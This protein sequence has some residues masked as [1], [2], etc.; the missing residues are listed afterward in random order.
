MFL[1]P[2]KVY[3]L[4]LISTSPIVAMACQ[5]PMYGDNQQ[6]N[7]MA[8]QA[9]TQCLNNEQYQQQQ[10]RQQQQQQQQLQQ[11]EAAQERRQYLDNLPRQM[12]PGY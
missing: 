1:N 9:Y 12:P 3:F 2:K 11:R 6:L 8:Q 7:N 5:P 10:Q 4:F